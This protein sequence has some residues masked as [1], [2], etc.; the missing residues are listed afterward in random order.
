M[1]C[2]SPLKVNAQG[3]ISDLQIKIYYPTDNGNK[4]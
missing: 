1:I 3:T 2:N 4:T